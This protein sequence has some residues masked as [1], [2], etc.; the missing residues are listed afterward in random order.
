MA[1]LKPNPVRRVDEVPPDDDG[2]DDA[3]ETDGR[4]IG[5]DDPFDIPAKRAPV[6][7]LWRWRVVMTRTSCCCRWTTAHGCSTYL[8]Y[9]HT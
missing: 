8:S 5:D 4:G 1:L 3:L 9:P 7:R 2:C 6:E